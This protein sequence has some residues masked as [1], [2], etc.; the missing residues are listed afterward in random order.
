MI[1]HRPNL[2][3]KGIFAFIDVMCEV[4]RVARCLEADRT[5]TSSSVRRLISELKK[6]LE[7][8]AESRGTSTF[9]INNLPSTRKSFSTEERY[10]DDAVGRFIGDEDALILAG[11]LLAVSK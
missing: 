7:T 9:I 4:R 3:E 2:G 1:I 10:R 6:T 8:M 11:R 5:V